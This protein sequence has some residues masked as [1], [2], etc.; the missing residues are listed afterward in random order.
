MAGGLCVRSPDDHRG[1]PAAL[2]LDMPGQGTDIETK[3]VEPMTN[4]THNHAATRRRLTG[5]DPAIAGLLRLP[6]ALV[7]AACVSGAVLA[8]PDVHQWP[9]AGPVPAS[10]PLIERGDGT[11]QVFDDRDEL[12]AA[13]AGIDLVHED[14]SGSLV[15]EFGQRIC[16][17][18]VGHQS[19]DPC[20]IPGDLAPGFGMRSSRGSIFSNQVDIDLVVLDTYMGLP[21]PMIG[22]NV[23]DLPYN[24][25]RIDFD[26]LVTVVGMDVLDGL[27][28][29][30]VQID[31]YGP[32]ESLIGSFTVQPPGQG[33][34]EFAG[35]VSHVPISRVDVNA[36]TDGG[37]ELIGRLLFGGGIGSLAAVDGAIDLG[38]LA[39]GSPSAGSFQLANIGHLALDNL[40]LQPLP[41]PFVLAA[42]GCTG[43][44]LAAG[45]TCTLDIALAGTDSGL[46]L[47]TWQPLADSGPAIGL[48]ADVVPARL[49]TAPGH[50]DFGDVAAG[51]SSAT[52]S[53]TVFNNTG[54][55]IGTGLPVVLPA[56]F[57][58]VGGDCPEAG[59][60]LAPD[61]SCQL[62]IVFSPPAVGE[63]DSE[64]AVYSAVDGPGGISMAG[65]GVQ[66]G[67]P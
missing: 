41:A 59:I 26:P 46:H 22:N 2:V 52:Q 35:M 30:P 37:A 19:N 51:S 7:A 61:A 24:P 34:T 36:P 21:T 28:G 3:G 6:L 43:T 27:L 49:Q 33:L 1:Q 45:Q 50:L 44:D 25:L 39:A 11:L 16:Y 20:F 62:D 64:L 48:R 60:E 40:Q 17:Q 54:A 53:V 58:R 66:G 14:F 42:D 47:A 63:Y 10:A 9:A 56:P 57:S 12:L 13:V 31:A 67:N 5:P 38:T 23:Q 55:V 8:Q 29:G 4:H 32:D 65:R 18:A 15:P